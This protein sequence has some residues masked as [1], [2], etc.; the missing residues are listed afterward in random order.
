MNGLWLA[1]PAGPSDG[2]EGFTLVSVSPGLGGFVVMFLL[3]LVVVF[4]MVD[5]SRRVRRIQ[6]RANAE[7]RQAWEQSEAAREAGDGSDAP[8][9]ARADAERGSSAETGAQPERDGDE[10]LR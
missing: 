8:T 9:D 6:A 4:L 10:P 5:L 7:E 2:G 3:A 1:A